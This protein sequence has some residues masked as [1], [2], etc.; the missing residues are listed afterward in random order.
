M[1]KLSNNK[2]NR[3][4]FYRKLIQKKTKKMFNKSKKNKTN[5]KRKN[6]NL[7]NNWEKTVSETYNWQKIV[8]SGNFKYH[9][10]IVRSKLA[11]HPDPIGNGN[12]F[13]SSDYGNNW[14]KHPKNFNYNWEGLSMNET[15]KYQSAIVEGKNIYTSSDYGNSWASV[16]STN[17]NWISVSMSASGQYQVAV[18]NGE[19]I[20]IS[21]NYGS[22]WISTATSQSWYSVDMSAS[23]Q[24]ITAVVSGSG[25]IYTCF[26]S[27]YSQGV[28]TIAGY[29]TDTGLTGSRGSLYY[30]ST[31]GGASGLRI[32][33]GAGW[34]S[35]KSFVIDHPN[36][37][38]KYLVHGCLEGPEAGVYYR[39]EGKITNNKYAVIKLPNYV[40]NLASFLT[41]QV[42]PIYNGNQ[43]KKPLSVSRVVDN[44]FTV[45]GE[46]GEFFW[47]VFGKRQDI[48]VEPSKTS[49]TVMG[50]GPYKWL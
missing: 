30:N 38:E 18:V 40:K 24:Y 37:K 45:H 50:E 26:N 2:K 7:L 27:V 10:A 48:Q 17:L 15:G 14:I 11:P 12:I 8:V 4:N 25:N 34:T 41:V 1:S 29:T 46:N 36:E 42:A 33:V 35:V 21:S 31:V 16:T 47:T 22:E 49:V 5:K 23:G 32:A 43:N 39:G 6:C 19:Y 44:Q 3:K 9:T 13:L 20:Y 28:V